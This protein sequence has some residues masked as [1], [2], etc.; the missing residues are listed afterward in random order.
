MIISIAILILTIFVS[1]LLFLWIMGESFDGWFERW[2]LI[3]AVLF[4][5][6]SGIVM[7]ALL[8]ESELRRRN[9]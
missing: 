3:A 1:I 7:S 9:N 5:L 8:I 6:A 4:F 2:M